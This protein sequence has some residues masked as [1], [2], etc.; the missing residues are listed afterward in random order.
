MNTTVDDYLDDRYESMA[1]ADE[2]YLSDASM[3][4]HHSGA[5][6][7]VPAIPSR[8]SQ[9]SSK[10]SDNIL[11]DLIDAAL[12]AEKCKDE[13]EKGDPYAS[14][15][16]SEEDGSISCDDIDDTTIHCGDG[17]AE[18]SRPTTRNGQE[19]VART[20]SFMFVG[21]PQLVEVSSTERPNRPFEATREKK[22]RPSPIR[23]LSNKSSLLTRPSSC[24]GASI[25]SEHKGSDTSS[26]SNHTL[27]DTP[28]KNLAA[29]LAMAEELEEHKLLGF[30]DGDS[31]RR[32][33]MAPSLARSSI[34]TAPMEPIP[35][36][37]TSPLSPTWRHFRSASRSMSFRA[38][39]RPSLSIL[40]FGRTTETIEEAEPTP[41][42]ICSL[43]YV[44]EA[45]VSPEI[46]QPKVSLEQPPMRYRDILK[47]A[48]RGAP[49]AQPAPE[50]PKQ[51]KLTGLLSKKR[52]IMGLAIFA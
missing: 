32:D 11:F 36:T 7:L 13:M 1:E 34:D 44:L 2:E 25:L 29:E 38:R 33:S 48:I 50:P 20:V 37:P 43:Q 45:P 39:K 27:E 51:G 23:L 35:E 30:L 28:T 22:R 40:N 47:G 3:E 52:S 12:L 17:S 6:A 15:A 41:A 21:K 46:H 19:S 42:S 4:S 49:P 5:K 14:Y 18:S 24:S 10:K 26:V 31:H 9:R 16:S 8:S